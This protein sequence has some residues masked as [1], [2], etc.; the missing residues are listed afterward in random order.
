[1]TDIFDGVRF[2]VTGAEEWG[3]VLRTGGSTAGSVAG[4]SATAS[5]GDPNLV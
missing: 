5:T 4:W 3:G 1:M 2:A